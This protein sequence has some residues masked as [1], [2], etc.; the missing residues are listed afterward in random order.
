MD[1]IYS[2]FIASLIGPNEAGQLKKQ[3]LGRA[4]L[5]LFVIVLVFGLI[6]SALFVVDYNRSVSDILVM[7]NEKAP[8]F[9]FDQGELKA[10]GKM[11]VVIEQSKDMIVIV[12]TTGKTDISALD[13]YETGVLITKNKMIDKKSKVEQRVYLFDSYKDWKF[14]KAD[15]ARWLPLLRWFSVGIVFFTVAGLFVL[16]LIDALILA[17][18]GLLMYS[19]MKVKLTFG[20]LYKLS[21]YYLTLPI[22]VHTVLIVTRVGIPSFT[23]IYYL[24]ALVYLFGAAK[25]LKNT[26]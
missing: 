13:K 16:K 4:F 6:C 11:P 20:D 17:V 23:F 14:T 10:T 1:H 3:P 12:D 7:F 5:Y 22:V 9:T 15:V 2:Q 21:L 19:I 24:I 26:P 8:D 25:T 18:I